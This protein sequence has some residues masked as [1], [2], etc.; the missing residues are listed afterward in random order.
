MAR[1]R[2]QESWSPWSI[3]IGVTFATLGQL[4]GALRWI[5]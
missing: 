2:S 1:Y 4:G 3:K 5:H